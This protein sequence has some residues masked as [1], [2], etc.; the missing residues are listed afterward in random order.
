MVLSQQQVQ[1][2]GVGHWLC[3]LSVRSLCA[4]SI[5]EFDQFLQQRS[6]QADSLPPAR[7]RPQM[8]RKED[9]QD[10]LFAL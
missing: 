8:Q 9:Q 3:G 4:P 2:L 7:H 5:A 1:V 6:L 10:E